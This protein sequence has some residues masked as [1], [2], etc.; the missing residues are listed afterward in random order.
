[1]YLGS[2][3]MRLI[4]VLVG[5]AIVTAAPA[6]AAPRVVVPR[7]VASG[8]RLAVRTHGLA[9][10]VRIQ[11]R[12]RGGDWHRLGRGVPR[13][14]Q[15]LRVRARGGDGTLTPVRRV[16]VR[17]LRL[18]AVGDVNLG[19]GPGDDIARHGPRYP[20][21]RVGRRLRAADIAFGNLECAVSRRGTAY[22]KTFTFRGRPSS[23]PAVARYGGLDVVNLANNH[24]G[25]FGD[26]A[27]LDTI[28]FARRAGLKP[29]GAGR[30][31][32]RA[33]RP[34]IVR[35]L[36]LRVAFVGF[37]VIEPPDFR[38]GRH[39][40]GTA[41]GFPSRVRHAVTVAR[42]R[43]DVVVATF[44]WGIEGDFHES[45]AQRALAQVALRAGATAVIGG[46]PH[47]LQP[48]RRL[49][50][51]VIAYSLGNFVFTPVRPGSDRTAILELRL[52]AGRV[53]RSRLRHGTIAG[54]RPSV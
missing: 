29:V 2:G 10:P 32:A 41:W 50:H 13:R 6:A 9:R 44:H 39:E 22:P 23:L 17:D 35:R 14:P 31:A 20:W 18:S 49:R 27:L 3:G 54:T 42:R 40:P 46:H 38:A 51:R 53:E 33:Y 4:G 12:A 8:G 24:A 48:L 5:A 47:V 28:R 45:P 19:D 7:A 36:G 43:A 34:V 16:R 21:S 37:S 11:V 30:N 15:L 52:S 1:M 26:G 25:D